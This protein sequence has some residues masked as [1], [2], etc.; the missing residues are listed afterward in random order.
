MAGGSPT[1][2]GD[3]WGVVPRERWGRLHTGHT[4]KP[5]PSERGDW[6]VFYTA[7]ADAA[8][9]RGPVPVDPHDAVAGLVV[10]EAAQRSAET[11]QVVAL[12]KPAVTR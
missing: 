7:F 11:G 10:L 9:R 8:R 3:A 2:S 4:T 1:A 12:G 5:W 6:T